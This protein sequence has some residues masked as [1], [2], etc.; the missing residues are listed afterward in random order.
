[1]NDAPTAIRL[2]PT[3]VRLT[4]PAPAGTLVFMPDLGGSV[5]YARALVQE[6]GAL[7]GCLGARLDAPLF[8]RLDRLTLPELGRHL[9]EDIARAALPQPLCLAGFSFA[10]SV[11]FEAARHLA[12]LGVQV[13]TLWLLDTEVLRIIP[14]FRPWRTAPLAEARRVV[15]FTRRNWRVLLG[16][17]P[18]PDI[19]HVYGQV[20]MY[21]R[22]HPK[23]CR[24][25]I[26]GLY[27]AMTDYHPEPWSGPLL[28]RRI[29]VV[30]GTLERRFRGFPADLGWRH[31]IPHCDLV[32]VSGQHLGMMT[33]HAAV[34]QLAAAMRRGLIADGHNKAGKTSA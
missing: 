3:L 9:A 22:E 25:I 31:L 12:R 11:A 24:D 4:P 13:D 34:R 18:D 30:R 33:D 27:R 8:A 15:G 5:F 23:G 32:D 20:P 21:L 2:P 29:V 17:A 28:P 10:G 16:G 6:I 19:L 7:V 1:M 26:R 14:G